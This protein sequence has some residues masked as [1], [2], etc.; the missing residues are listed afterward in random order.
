MKNINIAI[1][2]VGNCCSSLLQGLSFYDNLDIKENIHGLMHKE[3]GDFRPSD[4]AVVAAFDVDKRKVYLPLNR[5]IFEKPNCTKIFNLCGNLQPNPIV[6][7]TPILDGIAEHMKEYFQVDENQKELSKDEIITILK[8]TKTDIIINFLP[9]GSTRATEFWANIA[10]ESKCAF[11]NAIPEFIAS[12]KEWSEKFKLAN[13]PIIGDDIKSQLG[14]TILHRALADLFDQRGVSLDRTY[15]LNVAGNTDFANMLD[16]SRLKS[17]K[18]SKTEAVQST[19]S[20]RLKDEN[21][22]IGPSDYIS[23]QK[24]EKI[25]YLRMEGKIFGNIPM[26]LELRLSVEDSPNSG[27]IMVDA[28]RIAKIALDRKISGPIL[29]ACAYFCKHPPIQMEDHNARIQLE[30]FINNNQ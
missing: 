20:N 1:V 7:K 24:D 9:V 22:H 10:L 5:A 30:E 26:N 3:I 17:K 29:P 27:G 16:R 14:A 4:I 2:G 18:I 13:L 8:N 25:C 19:L 6:L 12:N 23:F 15:Q 21:I 28:I 11:I